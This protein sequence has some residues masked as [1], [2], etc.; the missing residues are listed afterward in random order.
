MALVGLR[1]GHVEIPGRGAVRA[2]LPAEHGAELD[3]HPLQQRVV[4]AGAHDLA[5]P[6]VMR[7]EARH[8]GRL[9]LHRLALARHER[10]GDVADQPVAAAEQPCLDMVQRQ[11]LDH[12]ARGLRIERQHLEHR[13][14]GTDDLA[15]IEAGR[16]RVDA[17][18]LQEHLHAAHRPAADQAQRDARLA[19]P[20]RRRPGGR[21][22]LLVAVDQRAVDVGNQ[23]PDP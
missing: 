22:E 20:N 9:E 21:R 3:L 18:R 7:L 23:Q 19:Q 8:H 1:I 10:S 6:V 4:D 15:A 5:D 2:H 17:E 13:A 14:V 11:R 12:Q 16:G